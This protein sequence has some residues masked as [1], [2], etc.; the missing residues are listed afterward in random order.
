MNTLL[1]CQLYCQNTSIE[2]H[3]V[4]CDNRNSKVRVGPSHKT[5]TSYLKDGVEKV[6][7]MKLPES[8]SYCQTYVL[9]TIL[10]FPTTETV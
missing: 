3:L 5:F 4:I 6:I 7:A 10:W 9:D 8:Q 2:L 1:E